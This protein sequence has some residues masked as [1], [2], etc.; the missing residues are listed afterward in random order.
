MPITKIDPHRICIAPMVNL[1]DRHY[2][3]M[4]RLITK[5]TM[6]YTEMVTTS[7]IMNN[8]LY[9]QILQYSTQEKPLTLQLGG[10]KPSELAYCANLAEKCGFSGVHFT[11]N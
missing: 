4:M 7:S 5:K 1:T 10:N 2:R 3:Y 6:L 9:Q 11:H 8:G